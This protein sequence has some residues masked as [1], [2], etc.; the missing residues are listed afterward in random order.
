MSLCLSVVCFVSIPVSIANV[1]VVELCVLFLDKSQILAD[2]PRHSVDLR[3]LKYSHVNT[4]RL[5][6]LM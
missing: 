3:D 6:Q 5:V 2:V 1:L 4:I